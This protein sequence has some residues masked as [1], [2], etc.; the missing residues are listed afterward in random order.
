MRRYKDLLVDLN[1][2][3]AYTVSPLF[4]M[5]AL[6]GGSFVLAPVKGGRQQ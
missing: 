1:T 3:G 4:P 6:D 2:H 5:A